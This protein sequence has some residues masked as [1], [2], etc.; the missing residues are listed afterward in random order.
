METGKKEL[1]QGDWVL[2]RGDTLLKSD[3]NLSKILE[4]AEQYDEDE[5]VITKEPSSDHCFY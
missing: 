1:K 2:F 5:V 4:E 3:S